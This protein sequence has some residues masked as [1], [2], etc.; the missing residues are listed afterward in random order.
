MVSGHD[1]GQEDRQQPDDAEHDAVEEHA[2]LQRALVGLPLPQHQPRQLHRAQLGDEGDGGA[3]LD[4]EQEDVGPVILD[5][6]WLEAERG[7]HIGDAG[8]IQIGPEHARA[9]M[10]IADRRQVALDAFVGG[11]S[12][13]EDDPIGIGAFGRRLDRHASGDSVAAGRGLDLQPVAPALVKLAQRGDVEPVLVLI[14][15]DGL[16][17]QGRRH[18]NHGGGERQQEA[19]EH[20]A[21][22]LGRHPRQQGFHR[23]D[24]I[25]PFQTE[26]LTGV[27]GVD[28]RA[29]SR[30]ADGPAKCR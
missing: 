22:T 15:H 28:R 2:V 18:P 30:R 6:V 1:G 4:R 8:R 16:E 14:D 19:R 23:S 20:H 13:R 21:R 10:A 9:H 11:V 7:G 26:R 24:G 5:A 27:S 17:R 25:Q 29:A 12:K 3:G